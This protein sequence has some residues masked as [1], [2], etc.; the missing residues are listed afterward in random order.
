MIPRWL[1]Q[2]RNE[3]CSRCEIKAVCEDKITMLENIPFCSLGKLH[4]LS[5]EIRWRQAWPDSAAPVSGCCDSAL[6]YSLQAPHRV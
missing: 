3:T 1:A 2:K 5:D 4:A 6:N